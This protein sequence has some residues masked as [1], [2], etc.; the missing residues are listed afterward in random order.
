MKPEDRWKS[1]ELESRWSG[2]W[3]RTGKPRL[4]DGHPWQ[5]SQKTWQ[6]PRKAQELEASSPSGAW[7]THWVENKETSWPSHK[8]WSDPWFP[9]TPASW[10]HTPSSHKTADPME[11]RKEEVPGL[12]KKISVNDWDTPTSNSLITPAPGTWPS[13]A[14]GKKKESE[15]KRQMKKGY[16]EG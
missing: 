13:T 7:V 8:Q 2:K 9:Q 11:H 10:E 4:V 3:H 12:K 14:G 6:N 1:K 16:W 5:A 15:G